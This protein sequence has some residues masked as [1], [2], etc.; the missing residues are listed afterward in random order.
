M[1][2]DRRRLF[3][4]L[5][6]AGAASAAQAGELP[7]AG[8]GFGPAAEIDAFTL[9]LRP[10]AADDQTQ[11]LQRAIEQSASSGAVLRLPPGIYRAGGLT[12]TPHAAIAGVAGATRIVMT[13]G[14]SMMA[15]TGADH[16][17]LSG[18]IL[19]GG[20]VPLPERRAL[21]QFAQGRALR[22]FDCEIINAG[23]NAI[24][25]DGIEGD[26]SGNTIAAAD[27]AIFSLNARGLRIGGNTIR[28][29][30]NNGILV[31]RSEAGDDGTLVFDNRIEDVANKAGGSG[32]YGNA[33]NVFR[34][35]NVIVRGNRIRNAA[36]S[37]VRG[38][39]A[40]N[41]Q[42]VGN[43]CTA[44]G[45]VALY[46]EFGFQGAVIANN[47]VDGAAL[48]VSVT[49]FNQDGRLAVVQGN[50]I[51]NLVPHRPQGT[52][53]NDLA[54]VGIGVEADTAVTGN[55]VEN[56]PHAGI[57]AGWGAYLRDVAI[58]SNVIRRAEYGITV[59]VAPGAGA[60][61]IADNMIA[62]T[63]SGAIIGMEWKRP[64]S[65]DLASD[66][67][68]RYAQLSIGGNRVR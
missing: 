41:L 64:V 3:A 50:L 24:A 44:L 58:S 43:T 68:K 7:T 59:S 14:P 39:A 35:G 10:N 28:G 36:F 66:G 23:G 32:Q 60:A 53:P 30:G 62:E 55:V 34:A 63:R 46:A 48:G 42:I 18:L 33:V 49:N 21:L 37:A 51:R 26:V 29:A 38:N 57:A 20:R 8:R 22:I 11:S 56:A 31:W 27:A 61:V 67:A 6:G 54:G 15:A 25:L 65:G 47:V 16:V 19:D 1:K 52:D 9:G 45:E 17:S 12:L 2:L 13:G 5:A 40:S 4:A